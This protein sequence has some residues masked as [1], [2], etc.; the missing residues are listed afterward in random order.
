MADF[1]HTVETRQHITLFQ[2]FT[3]NAGEGLRM[4]LGSI[5]LLK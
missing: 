2:A 1:I 4:R 5:R 3:T